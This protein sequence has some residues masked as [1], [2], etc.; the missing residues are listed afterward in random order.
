[1][2]SG[3]F[4]LCWGN[5]HRDLRY[6]G[7]RVVADDIV[8]EGDLARGAGGRQVVF[9]HVAEQPLVARGC[10]SVR[11]TETYGQAVRGRPR[12]DF[13]QVV[14]G[15]VEQQK[16]LVVAIKSPAARRSGAMPT[17]RLPR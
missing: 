2:P 13:T 6:V 3:R 17:P 1:M 4:L 11:A 15:V 14:V 5:R 8:D 7:C 16:D 12:L 10:L 9:V